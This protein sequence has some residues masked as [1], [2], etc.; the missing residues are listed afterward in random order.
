MYTDLNKRA[1]ADSR[2]DRLIELTAKQ[3]AAL[4]ELH[5]KIDAIPRPTPPPPVVIPEIIDYSHTIEEIKNCIP[6]IQP[7]AVSFSMLSED[8]AT[9]KIRVRDLESAP[10]PEMY[11]PPPLPKDYT[12]HLAAVMAAHFAWLIYLTFWN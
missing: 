5:A 12:L 11:I 4:Q 7:L 2:V 8:L 1:R 9:L 3:S 6:D 10:E